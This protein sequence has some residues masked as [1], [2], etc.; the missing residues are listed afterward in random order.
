[1]ISNVEHQNENF[2]NS[3]L[4]WLM[5]IILRAKMKNYLNIHLF[6]KVQFSFLKRQILSQ[7]LKTS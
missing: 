7:Y 4:K 6:F 1:M 3:K 2:V 5:P